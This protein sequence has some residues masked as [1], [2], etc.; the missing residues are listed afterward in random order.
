MLIPTARLPNS[1]TIQIRP[2]RQTGIEICKDG[3]ETVDAR[4][5]PID[6]IS[7]VKDETCE[8]RT[9]TSA[10]IGGNTTADHQSLC[11]IG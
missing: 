3:E 1:V 10:H 4:Y 9:L 8:H 2:V 11:S 5:V 7:D 6:D